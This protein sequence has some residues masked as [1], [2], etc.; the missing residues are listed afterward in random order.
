MKKCLFIVGLIMPLYLSAQIKG[1]VASDTGESLLGASVYWSGTS[2]GTIT[3]EDGT[4]EVPKKGV[5]T[6]MLVASFVGHTPDTIDVSKED[7]IR[8]VL[9]ISDGLDEVVVKGRRE[10][11]SISNLIPVKTEKITQTEL[12]KAACCDLAGCFGTQNTVQ[13][14]T[15]NVIT[16]SKE[17]RILGLSGVYTQVL[18]D[19]LPTIQG[20]SYTYGISSTPGT[21]VDNISVAKGA[22]SVIQGFE[23]ISGQINVGTID[24]SRSDRLLLNGYI[25]N[26]GEK[27]L[28]AN[29]AMKKGRWSNLTALH[30]V[31]P[32][33]RIDGD[34]DNFLDVPLLTRYMLFNKWQYGNE[35]EWGWSSKIGVR[36]LQEDRIGGQLDFESEQMGST[37]VYGQTVG[38]TQPEI[39]TKTG[40]RFGDSQAITFFGSAYH[41]NQESFFGS[42]G[43]EGQQTNI[44]AKVQ[45]QLNY[46]NHILKTG[47]SYRH[48]DLEETIQF[49]DT[50]LER[51]YDGDYRR[52]ERIA[53]F[54]AENTLRFLNDRLT[55]MTGIRGDHHN[56]FGYRVTPRALFK[57]DFGPR[58]VIRANVGTGWRTVNLFSENVGLLASSRDVIFEEDLLPERAVNYGVN[59]IQKLDSDNELVTGYLSLDYYRT[60]FQNQIFPDYDTDSR[61]AIIKNFT[62]TSL[63]SGFQAELNLRFVDRFDFKTGYNF[64]DVFREIGDAKVALP[65]NPRHKFF[66]SL[67]YSPTGGK[68]HF[69]LNAHWY[70]EHRLP[71]TSQNPVELQ[72]PDFSKSFALVNTQVTYNVGKFEIYAGVENVFNFRQ[73]RPILSWENPFST[74]FDT[75]SV[76]GPTRGRESYLGVRYRLAQRADFDK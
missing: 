36:F 52:R 12:R 49:S 39:W 58:T 70:G 21:L 6:S 31:Q 34:N 24:P 74:Y 43:Y 25:N 14:Q 65:F 3:D 44:Y 40:Y 29:Y 17:L 72:R 32:A 37:D 66:T 75:S 13:A 2:I 57:Y 5:N 28:N 76:W 26:F 11:V 10:G 20:L 4:F 73:N 33:S 59:F 23:S 51:T 60:V 42:L 18:M 1:H 67:G 30:S 38:I 64:L 27:H 56:Q 53:G 50:V 7:Y 46:G 61:K 71:N 15:T 19:G 48:L 47:I 69:E 55:F 54:F 62:G 63:S 9:S 8:F 68:F 35:V 45:H 41:Q 16:N 22:N